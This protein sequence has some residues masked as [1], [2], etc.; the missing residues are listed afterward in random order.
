MEKIVFDANAM[1]SFLYEEKNYEKVHDILQRAHENKTPMFLSVINY[2][3]IYYSVMR[4]SGREK[5]EKLK[6]MLEGI[7]VELVPVYTPDAQEAAEIKAVK[8]M[9]YADCFA[10]ALA[11]RLGAVIVTGDPEFREVEKTVKVRW[12]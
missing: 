6:S 5:A 11:K 1:L 12:V 2:G 8:K 4:Y 7:P 9:S 10:A 3:E